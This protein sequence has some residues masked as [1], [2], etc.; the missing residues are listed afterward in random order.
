MLH[1]MR[2]NPPQFKLI[3]EG[4]KKTE[5][6]LFDDK[7]KKIKID[8]EIVFAKRP[9]YQEKITCKVAKL[10]RFDSFKELLQS[11]SLEEL[12]HKGMSK[13]EYLELIG[14]FYSAE[15]EQKYGVLAIH[16][17]SLN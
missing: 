6:R 14:G 13:E 7:R 9:E 4:L 16:L 1:Y 15:E 5:A 11:H 12:G 2:L 3:K 8:D 10:E 17:K